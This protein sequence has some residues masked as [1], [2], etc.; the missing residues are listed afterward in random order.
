M[1]CTF[2]TI[3]YYTFMSNHEIVVGC[4][5]VTSVAASHAISYSS[6]Q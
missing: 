4:E 2:P 1:I 5:F 3:A 6:S